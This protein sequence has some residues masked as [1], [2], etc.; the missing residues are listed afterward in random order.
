M[1]KIINSLEDASI[2]SGNISDVANNIL[3]SDFYRDFIA[4]YHDKSTVFVINEAQK[5]KYVETNISTPINVSAYKELVLN[6]ASTDRGDFDKGNLDTAQYFI[7]LT[8]SDDAVGTTTQEIWYYLQIQKTLHSSVIAIPQDIVNNFPYIFAVRIEINHDFSDVLFVSHFIAAT[9][10]FPIDVLNGIKTDIEFHLNN[11][12]TKIQVG[13]V[14]ASPGV[15]QITIIG[16]K[17]YIDRYSA[18]EID[19]GVNSEIHTIQ[20]RSTGLFTLGQLLDGPELLYSHISSP[21]YLYLPVRVNKQSKEV[22]IPSINIWGQSPE[23][24]SSQSNEIE[25]IYDSFRISRA[26]DPPSL[27]TVSERDD[28]ERIQYVITIDCESRHSKIIS[29]MSNAVKRCITRH[30]IWVNGRRLAIE[31]TGISELDDIQPDAIPKL[32]FTVDV[33]VNES[34]SDRVDRVGIQTINVNYGIIG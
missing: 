12:Y 13:A 10:A 17:D 18:I 20:D 7:R 31:Q 27:I 14:T 28:D 33:F 23:H 16:D 34:L 2:W 11:V 21:V 9:D 8:F 15:K 1:F 25:K 5:G 26:S 19:N 32:Q 22:I 29:I 30:I 24:D 6:I 4:Y 3:D